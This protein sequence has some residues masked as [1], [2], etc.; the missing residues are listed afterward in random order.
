MRSR[1]N[2]EK[3]PIF[4]HL[5]PSRPAGDRIDKALEIERA[6][7]PW[8]VKALLMVSTAALLPGALGYH[9]ILSPH[10]DNPFDGDD[11]YDRDAHEQQA[12]KFVGAQQ[13]GDGPPRQQVQAPPRDE[14]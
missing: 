4:S 7:R 10:A 13:A 11:R 3:E 1:R 6:S 12:L 2:Q 9:D 14:R 8:W 5:R